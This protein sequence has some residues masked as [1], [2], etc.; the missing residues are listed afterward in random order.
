MQT[1]CEQL[2][3]M[4]DM[5]TSRDSRFAFAAVT[6]HWIGRDWTLKS[7]LLDFIHFKGSHTGKRIAMHIADSLRRLGVLHKVSATDFSDAPVSFHFNLLTKQLLSVTTDN[8]SNN[9]TMMRAL[10]VMDGINAEFEATDSHVRCLPHIL[11]IAVKAGLE[12]LRIST[13]D[14]DQMMDA[15]ELD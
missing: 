6:G 11:H 3:I 7:I 8:S 15:Q 2:S 9:S 10:A 1:D 13:V 5:W 12:K 4:T 14:E